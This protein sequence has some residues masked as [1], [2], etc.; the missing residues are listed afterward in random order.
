MGISPVIG[1]EILASFGMDPDTGC[2]DPRGPLVQASEEDEV[3]IAASILYRKGYPWDK[4]REIADKAFK[5]ALNLYSVEDLTKPLPEVRRVVA[6]L[7]KAGLKTAVATLDDYQRTLKVLDIIGVRDFFDCIVGKNDVKST[8]PSPDMIFTICRKL[9]VVP[10]KTVMVGDSVNDM[11]MGKR[12]KVALTIGVLN[13][14]NSPDS[15]SSWA[16]VTIHSL[17]EIEIRG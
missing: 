14:I 13:G 11:I 10:E 4:A 1:R 3:I 15:F 5:I 9:H 17:L 6:R 8:K 16:D 7:K 2:I 12:A